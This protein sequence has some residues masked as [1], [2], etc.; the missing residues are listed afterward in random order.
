M[1]KNILR[2]ES[3]LFLLGSLYFYYLLSGNWMLFFLFLLLPDVSMIGYLKSK[4]LGSI[5]YN[6][7]HN[8]TLPLLMIAVG[9]LLNNLTTHALGL[10]LLA[11]VAMDRLLGFGLKYP[12]A[13]KDT[14]M[15]KL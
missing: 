1:V 9:F 2:L 10:I 8:F 5:T 13:F 14:H 3:L 7:I 4:R 15:Q 6:L 12:T 11:H